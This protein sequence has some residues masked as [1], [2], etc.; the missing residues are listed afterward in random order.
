MSHRFQ[1][2]IAAAALALGFIGAASASPADDA[3]QYAYATSLY[4]QARWAGA[5]GRFAALADR[6]H[7]D[8][9]RIALIMLRYGRE[10]Y[11]TEWSATD[12]Q[13][14]RWVDAANRGVSFQ[15]GRSGD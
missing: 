11:R 5:F 14:A 15:V 6:G 9:A 2:R 8:A 13:V 12:A 10:L 1:L 7:P 4:Q 3:V